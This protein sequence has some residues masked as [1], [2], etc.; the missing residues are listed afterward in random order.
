MKRSP[1]KVYE[2][3]IIKIDKS[4]MAFFFWP[5]THKGTKRWLKLCWYDFIY[6]I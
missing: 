3:N 4:V 1:T 5:V 6:F 2:K